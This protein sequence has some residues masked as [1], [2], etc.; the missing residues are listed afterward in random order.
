MWTDQ[1]PAN[2]G[3]DYSDLSDVFYLLICSKYKRKQRRK[4]TNKHFQ[5]RNI[6]KYKMCV[7]T[8]V[9]DCRV[10]RS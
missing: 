3:P 10:N 5:F 8:V 4:Q 1:C 2:E 6:F 9:C 7:S